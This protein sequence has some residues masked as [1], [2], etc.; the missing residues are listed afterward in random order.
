MIKFFRNIRRRL[1]SESKF[2]KYLLYAVGEIIL[3]VIGILIALQINNWNEQ[4]KK[5]ERSNIALKELQTEVIKT[6]GIIEKRN[7]DN[8]QIT[9]LIKTYL[10]GKVLNPSD[11]LK[12]RIVKLSFAYN[13]LQLSIPIIDREVSA[14]NLIINQDSLLKELKEFDN[15]HLAANQQLSYLDNYWNSNL[16]NFLEKQELMLN[17]IRLTGK[18]DLEAD[19]LG[20]LYESAEYKNIIAMEY[21][22]LEEYTQ[23]VDNL[24]KQLEKVEKELPVITTENAN[25]D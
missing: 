3:V 25:D 6:K 21:L 16:T 12:N 4:R 5:I 24:Y 9:G 19:G 20:L 18:I 17:F 7:K 2:S 8:I 14:D 10:E 13:P 11:S 22:H 15:L 1:W 23:H